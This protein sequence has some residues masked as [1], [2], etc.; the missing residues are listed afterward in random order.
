MGELQAEI[1]DLES[2]AQEKID[3]I[4]ADLSKKTEPLQRDRDLQFRSLE[5]F[6]NRKRS[7]FGKLRSRKLNFGKMGWHRSTAIITSE[8]TLDL[9]KAKLSKAESESCI[10]VKVS[11]S[12]KGLGKLKEDKLALVKAR[13]EDTEVFFVEPNKIEAVDYQS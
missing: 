1:D 4:V 9:I 6:C 12:K 11:I 10:S 3:K 5:A 8:K 2:E 13:R 7:D